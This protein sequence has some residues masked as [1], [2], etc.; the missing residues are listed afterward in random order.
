ME[1][2]MTHEEFLD[3]LIG[4]TVNNVMPRIDPKDN[5]LKLYH[6]C[7]KKFIQFRTICSSVFGV[8]FYLFMTH[9]LQFN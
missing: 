4:Y 2:S 7:D 1:Y 8:N 9:K 5:K 3:G 6:F